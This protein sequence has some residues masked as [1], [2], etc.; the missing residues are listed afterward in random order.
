MAPSFR[1]CLI[2][3]VAPSLASLDAAGT[4]LQDFN[5][6]RTTAPIEATRIDIMDTGGCTLRLRAYGDGMVRVQAAPPGAG[7]PPD[8][9]TLMIE[10]HDLGGTL[11]LTSEDETSLHVTTGRIGISIT[12]S[13]LRLSFRDAT[14]GRVLLSDASGIDF[15]REA[16]GYH[17]APDPAEQFIGWGQKRLALQEALFLRGRIERRNY[18][19]DGYPGRGS[20]GVLIVPFFISSKGYGLFANSTYPNEARFGGDAGE[21]C[22][23]F[24]TGGESAPADYVFILGPTPAEVLDRYTQLTGRPRLPPKSIFGLH[25]SDND[26]RLPD[27]KPIDE[28]WWRTM[29]ANHRAAGFPLDHMVF[30]NDWRAAAPGPDAAIGAW[31]GSQ[32]DWEPTRYPEPQAFR[33]W[34]D[35]AG[36]TLTVDLN[37]N[38]CD[39]SAGWCRS[40]NVLPEATSPA[41]NSLPDYSNPVTRAWLWQLL[42]D[43]AFD[44]ALG[45]PG[46]AIW[47]DESDGVYVPD[48]T[49]LANGRTW[50][51]MKNYYFFLTAYAAVAE[52]W[53]DVE[54]GTTPGIGEAKR[55]HVWIRGG[56]AGMQRYAS[57]WTGD[58]DFTERFY[59]G[60]IIG[61]QASGLAGFPYFNHD[62]GGF[63]ANAKDPTMEG[64]LEGPDDAY[65]V[66]WGMAFGSF[67]PIW[68]PHGYGYPRWPL[69][70][71]TL[72]QEAFRRYATLRYELM[73]YI[74][75]LAHEAHER[76]LP[77]ARPLPLVYPTTGDAWLPGNQLQYHW[78]DALLVAPPP[79]I[80]AGDVAH[81][82]WFPPAASW[83][84]FWTGERLSVAA[85][86][87]NHRVTSRSGFL[88]VFVRAGAIVPRQ[89]FALSTAWLS[90]A[91]LTLDVYAG[92]DGSFTLIEDDGVSER[93][94]TRGEIRRTRIELQDGP[95]SRLI[96]GAASGT[97]RGA[98]A[99]RDLVVRVHG[100][101]DKP[102]RISVDGQ[103]SEHLSGWLPE[104]RVLTITVPRRLVTATLALEWQ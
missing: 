50:R 47:L 35:A 99:A 101:R 70:R 45:Y 17:F 56:T 30:D 104:A 69:N 9:D 91:H 23:R 22:L 87:G 10:R 77:M 15:G 57:H 94:R 84:D 60:Q 14:T 53:D 100:L 90:D 93:F 55:P 86:G 24:E 68:R 62:A 82:V 46:D 41:R 73:P 2:A 92:A 21:F 8:E 96:V 4:P 65:Y 19:E 67:T 32:F 74:Y 61:M 25:L 88:P 103:T 66:Q 85:S 7:F 42:W 49:V 29:V 12:K 58:I 27:N 28:H 20:Q 72:C 78:G 75:T 31:S 59:R 33:R 44:P 98:S 80:T 40:F 76:G 102:R 52:G 95:V 83:Y 34:Y 26:P 71:N 6:L 16:L 89:K 64:S 79:Q 39:D 48:T 36:L 43:K 51:E 38:N 13:P 11:R 63:G 3:A 97:F 81:D 37:L 54:G 1:R 5:G 18:G